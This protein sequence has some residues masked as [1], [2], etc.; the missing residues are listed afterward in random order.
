MKNN[1]VAVIGQGPESAIWKSKEGEIPMNQMSEEHLQRAFI[2]T[3]MNLFK[4]HQTATTFVKLQ[5]QLEE[6]ALSRGLKLKEFDE[7][8]PNS[9]QF[10]KNNRKAKHLSKY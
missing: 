2:H 1:V 5:D 8:Y 3:Q 6:E 10:F 9:Q 7:L 4:L